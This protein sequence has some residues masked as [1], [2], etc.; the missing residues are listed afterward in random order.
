MLELKGVDHKL[1]NVLPGNQRIHLR[2]AGFRGGTVPALKLDGRKIQGSMDIAREL[3]AIAPD[4]PLFPA[5]VTERARVEEAERWGDSEFQSVPRRILRWGMTKDAGLRR[6]MAETDGN[7]PLPALAG[8]ATGPVSR[9]YARVVSADEERVRR[10]IA[11]LPRLLDHIDELMGEGVIGGDPPNAA[12]LQIM[13][14]VRSLL[15][16]SDFEEQVG[17]RSFAPLARELFP[18]FPEAQVP[19]FVE[20]LGVA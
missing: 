4:P 2:L 5:D 11:E 10:D 1:V 9:Y 19:P 13:C 20:R 8:R 6:W 12:T 14:T 16:F 15:G 17:A 18:H 3:D 7:L